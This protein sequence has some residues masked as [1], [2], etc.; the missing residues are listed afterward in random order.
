M[1]VAEVGAAGGKK[2]TRSLLRHEYLLLLF[3]VHCLLCVSIMLNQ[4]FETV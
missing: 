3:F 4:F 2:V 1:E